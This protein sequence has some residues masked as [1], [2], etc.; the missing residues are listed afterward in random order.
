MTSS[1]CCHGMHRLEA[2]HLVLR[3]ADPTTHVQTCCD[4][5]DDE[6]HPAEIRPTWADHR[7]PPGHRD[8][9]R[10]VRDRVWRIV[11]RHGT[12]LTCEGRLVLSRIDPNFHEAV[13]TVYLSRCIV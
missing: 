13:N 7:R 3:V 11:F 2:T 8:V 6:E 12:I 4:S 1:T 5:C 9:I 10:R